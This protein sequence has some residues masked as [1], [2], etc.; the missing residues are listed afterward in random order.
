MPLYETTFIA[1]QDIP[2]TEVDKLAENFTNVIKENG[3]KVVKKE[4]WGLRTLAYRVNKNRK[5]HYTFLGIDAPAAAV[6]EMERLMR[7]NEDVM[8]N[9]TVRVEDIDKNPTAMMRQGGDEEYES[10]GSRGGNDNARGGHR[11]KRDREE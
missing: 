1:R 6:H 3:G 8:R 4:Y 11:G 10:F 5:G 9:L 2:V 7:L